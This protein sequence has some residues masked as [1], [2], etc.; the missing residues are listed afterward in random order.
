LLKNI[1]IKVRVHCFLMQ[2][3]INKCFS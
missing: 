3:V 1:D 2:V